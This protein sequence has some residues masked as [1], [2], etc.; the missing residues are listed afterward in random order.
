MSV[1]NIAG[2][3]AGY[4]HTAA[5]TVSGPMIAVAATLAVAGTAVLASLLG[6][7]QS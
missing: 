5:T 1:Q 4:R 3:A 6:R 7:W 2:A